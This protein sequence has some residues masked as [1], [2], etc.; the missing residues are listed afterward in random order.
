MALYSL[1]G[2]GEKLPFHTAT[3]PISFAFLAMA[4]WATQEDLLRGA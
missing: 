4:L 2:I 1:S 3:M